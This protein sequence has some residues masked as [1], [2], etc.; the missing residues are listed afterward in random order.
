[1]LHAGFVTS[2]F[3]LVSLLVFGMGSVCE[4]ICLYKVHTIEP[5]IAC[6]M[7][8]R[9]MREITSFVKAHGSQLHLLLLSQLVLALIELQL[10]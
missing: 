10:Y 4:Y 3:C 7:P 9:C 2:Y 8:F 1:M 6:R 5:H